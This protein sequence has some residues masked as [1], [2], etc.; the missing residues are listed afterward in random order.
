M[1]P[2]EAY[3]QDSITRFSVVI[4]NFTLKKEQFTFKKVIKNMNSAK[5]VTESVT[6]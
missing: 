3:S 5:R 6:Q 2:G 1:E 4:K